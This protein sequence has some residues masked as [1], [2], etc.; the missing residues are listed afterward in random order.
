[1][2]SEAI[3]PSQIKAIWVKAQSFGTPTGVY[4]ADNARR[5]VVAHFEYATF[6]VG[7]RGGMIPVR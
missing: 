3:T 1:M 2:P 4:R 6:I 7:P 5:D